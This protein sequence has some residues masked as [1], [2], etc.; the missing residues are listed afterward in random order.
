MV[1]TVDIPATVIT[2]APGSGS[3]N[4]AALE[5]VSGDSFTG[6]IIL[7]QFFAVSAEYTVIGN[8]GDG[9]ELFNWS[10]PDGASLVSMHYVLIAYR[11]SSFTS[12]PGDATAVSAAGEFGSVPTSLPAAVMRSDNRGETPYF[13]DMAVSTTFSGVGEI[14]LEEPNPDAVLTDGHPL[15]QITTVQSDTLAAVCKAD[16]L[17]IR[18]VYNEAG[19]TTVIPPLRQYP[20]SDGLGASSVRRL[21]PPPPTIQASNRRGPSAIL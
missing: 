19:A 16:Y 2:A 11:E 7:A 10:L 6:N 12:P 14:L 4:P 3:F 20:R 21:W 17:A 18:V 13:P 9:P 1:T 15:N 5:T 8:Y